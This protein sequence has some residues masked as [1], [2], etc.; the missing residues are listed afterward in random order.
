MA[1][2][3]LIDQRLKKLLSHMNAASLQVDD[4]FD[5]SQYDRTGNVL[6]AR[7]FQ[8]LLEHRKSM[9]DPD[10]E[11]AMG[12]GVVKNS[13]SIAR[14]PCQRCRLGQPFLLRTLV[15]H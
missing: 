5:H 15:C 2:P 1:G 14:H 12:M 6:G 3:N 7:I 4:A 8:Q 11:G 13:A 10:S 9:D